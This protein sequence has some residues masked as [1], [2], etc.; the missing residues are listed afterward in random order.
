MS[1]LFFDHLLVLEEVEV[2]INRKPISKEEK[3]ELWKLIDGVIQ[4]RVMDV[5]L[6]K[7]P[8]KHHEE[9]LEKFSSFPHDERL[10]EYLKEKVEDIEE[11]IK[12]EVKLL[13]KDFVK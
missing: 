9:F 2:F 12:K 5:V 4:T 7:L 13:E 1:K 11:E 10:L 8:R 6:T 3:E